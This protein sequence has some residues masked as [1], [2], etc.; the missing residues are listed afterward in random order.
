[1]EKENKYLCELILKYI[2]GYVEQSGAK[3]VVLGLSGGLDSA[4]S[5]FLSRE[6]LGKD[7]VLGLILPYRLSSPE[8]VR[9]AWYVADS[10]GIDCREVD[11]T[12]QIDAY[13]R[14][15]DGMENLRLGNKIARERMSV[16]YDYSTALNLLVMG[17]NNKTEWLLGYFTM[18]G[19]GVAALEPLGDLYKTEV[20]RLAKY[21]GVPQQIIEKEPTADLWPG[22]SDV[23]EIGFRYEDIDRVLYLYWEKKFSREKLVELGFSEDLVNRVIG[24]VKN[25]SFKRRWP[26]ILSL[27]HLLSPFYSI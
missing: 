13:C 19:D 7:R 25:S 24:M 27:R 4:V 12:P 14:R 21:L 3:G 16:L 9:D 17:T 8:S 10:L 23:Q 5:A 11:L 6:A 18:W 15:F 20:V 26:E 2:M 1:M 22:Q